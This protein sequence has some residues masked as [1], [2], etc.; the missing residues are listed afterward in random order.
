MNTIKLFSLIFVSSFFFISSDASAI[1]VTY[2]PFPKGMKPLV[3]PVKSFTKKQIKYD[4]GEY[5][6]WTRRDMPEYTVEMD[7]HYRSE[8]P[9]SPAFKLFKDKEKLLEGTF[10]R[11]DMWGTGVYS[12]DFNSDGKPDFCL[13]IGGSGCGLAALHSDVI[14]LISTPSGYRQTTFEPYDFS[15]ETMFLKVRGRP[16]ILHTSFVEGETGKDGKSHNYWVFNLI[17]FNKDGSWEFA[18]SQLSGF[19]A[20]ILYT[21]KENHKATD[22]LTD[23]QKRSLWEKQKKETFPENSATKAKKNLSMKNMEILRNR[24]LLSMRA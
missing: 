8:T 17:Q 9:Q 22:Q 16:L 4:N 18:N 15:P 23:E 5:N 2:S 6:L 11:N 24:R 1:T 10:N 3:F 14:F 21:F 13:Y 19:P 12:S 20:W 7:F